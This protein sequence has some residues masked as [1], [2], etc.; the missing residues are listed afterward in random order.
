MYFRL[1]L[2]ALLAFVAPEPELELIYE[3]ED[4]DRHFVIISPHGYDGWNSTN[5]IGAKEIWTRTEHAVV[6]ESGSHRTTMRWHI[7]CDEQTF[8]RGAIRLH[9]ENGRQIGSDYYTGYYRRHNY[10]PFA[11]PS[12][13]SEIADIACAETAN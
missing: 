3:D 2:I 12:I 6:D 7:L 11:R 1:G 8:M 4:G 9:D 13:M 5:P 10:E